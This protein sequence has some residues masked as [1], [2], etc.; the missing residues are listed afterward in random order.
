MR[1]ATR[2][3]ITAVSVIGIV[4]LALGAR[5]L[6]AFGVFS[7]VTPGFSGTCH[8]IEGVH[9]PEDIVI[10][11]TL[12][13]A[14]IS[15]SDLRARLNGRPAAQD[16][17]YVLKLNGA[18]SPTKLAGTP[19]DFHPHGISLVRGGGGAVTLFAINHRSDGT[20][21]IASFDVVM[22]D[23]E[24]V[25]HEIGNIEGG[26]LI[27]PN[28]IA[29]VDRV[30]FYVVNDHTSKT[31]LGR[32]LDDWL[33]LP[34]ANVLYFDGTFFRIVAERL[35][36]PAGVVLSPDGRFLYVSEA[37]NRRLDTYAR[38]DFSGA[39]ESVGTLAIPSNPDN[40][41][42]DDRGRLWVGAHPKLFAMGAFFADPAKPA[43]SQVFR[44]ALSDGVP[45]AA[46]LTYSD[47]G[48]GIGGASVAAVLGRRLLVGSPLDAK[49]LDCTMARE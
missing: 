9:G 26:Q 28:A 36:A 43:P 17:L 13:V 19:S 45:Q 35:N 32:T 38:H 25:L 6:T 27:S 14:L 39:L 33:I 1:P 15:A 23:G 34:R 29:A 46:T 48:E 40:L 24:I 16:G 47:R 49:I 42:F 30:R 18:S 31:Q 41:R 2:A 22:K 44:V 37:F 8:A 4:A 7:D 20:S 5:T 10:D 21:S 3:A 12:G 11:K